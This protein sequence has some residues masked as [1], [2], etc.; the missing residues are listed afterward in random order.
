MAKKINRKKLKI[1]EGSSVNSLLRSSTL[2]IQTET[3]PVDVSWLCY[4]KKASDLVF[5]I[6]SYLE[7]YSKKRGTANLILKYLRFVIANKID[8]NIDSLHVY[9]NYIESKKN[10]GDTTKYQDFSASRAFYSHL[11]SVGFLP[12]SVLPKNFKPG[13]RKI[14]ATFIDLCR[15]EIKALVT[16]KHKEIIQVK[17]QLHLDDLSASS[18][19]LCEEWMAQI[20]SIAFSQIEKTIQDWMFLD[21]IIEQ[22]EKDKILRLKL[23]Q[24]DNF[25][26]LGIERSIEAAVSILYLKYG[27][28]IPTSTKWPKGLVDYCKCRGWLGSRL[29]GMF[30]PT[31]KTLDNFLVLTLANNTLMPNVDSVAFYMYVNCL[32]PGV[33]KGT[34]N[35]QLGKDRGSSVITGSLEKQHPLVIAIKELS[36]KITKCIPNMK[37]GVT[38]EN[39]NDIPLF[40]HHFCHR[41]YDEIKKLDTATTAD[42][43]CRFINKAAKIEP[44]LLPLIKNLTG[45][46]F[47]TTHLLIRRLR[48]QNIFDIAQRAHHKNIST[49][50]EYLE[51]LEVESLVEHRMRLFQKYI[52][53][54]ARA[55]IEKR[56]GNGFF[57]DKTEN[58]DNIDKECI[59]IDKCYQ[60]DCRRIV[61]ESEEIVAEWIAWEKH[62]INM[63]EQLIKH[64][65]ERWKNVWELNLVQYQTLLNLTSSSMKKNAQSLADN[66]ILPPL[67]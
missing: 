18:L 29:R 37:Q 47:R 33:D 20:S 24:I 63:K 44:K 23:L 59:R 8:I 6:K 45:E 58:V 67:N 66:I 17:E 34:T 50:N 1:N 54:N 30:F 49:T 27:Y 13:R 43:V 41:E 46:N 12:H 19:I 3:Y 21:K 5:E 4:F 61:F 38:W 42:M 26:D 57:C 62:I 25:S 35:F 32:Q 65:E 11:I 16:D 51:R 64:N 31:V 10:I 40:L 22:C 7:S 36:K 56:V 60:C 15:H 55:S 2:I 28:S 52:I 48:G 9:K 39:E 14:K 53:N